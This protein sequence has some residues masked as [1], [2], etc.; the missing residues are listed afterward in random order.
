MLLNGAT[1]TDVDSHSIEDYLGRLP[2]VSDVHMLRFN[3]VST[4]GTDMSVHLAFDSWSHYDELIDTIRLD[5]T[6]RFGINHL[7]VQ[8]ELSGDSICPHLGQLYSS[9]ASEECSH[10]H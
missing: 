1:P 6:D 8:P 9:A 2:G 10:A 4:V 5:M 7:T 3:A